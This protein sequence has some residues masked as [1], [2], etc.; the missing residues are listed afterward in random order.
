MLLIIAFL[1]HYTCKC[2]PSAPLGAVARGGV[3]A[4]NLTIRGPQGRLSFAGSGDYSLKIDDL[5]GFSV[6]AGTVPMMSLDSS[7]TVSLHMDTFSAKDGLEAVCVVH[8]RKI[9]VD[10]IGSQR[11]GGAEMLGGPG[12]FSKDGESG[13]ARVGPNGGPLDYIWTETNFSK[14]GALNICGG[15]L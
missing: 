14:P 1:F 7:G 9:A 3:S 2:T 4:P 11:C 6:N 5:G 8:K 12:F 15:A 13:Y 10:K